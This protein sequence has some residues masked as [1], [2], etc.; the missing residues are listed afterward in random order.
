M[1][2]NHYE[3]NGVWWFK[4]QVAGVLYRRSLRTRSRTVAKKLAAQEAAKIREFAVSGTERHSYKEAVLKW[5]K[6]FLT[7]KEP[8]TARRYVSSAKQLHSH[9]SPLYV[10]QIKPATI[11]AYV[12]IRKKAGATDV[13]IRRDLTA[14][15]SILRMCVSWGWADTNVAKLWDRSVLSEDRDA[16]HRLH[17]PSFD[18]V[19]AE[20]PATLA[21]LMRFL[22]ATGM[23]LEEAASLRRDQIKGGDRLFITKTKTHAP[24]TII[25]SAE[26]KAIVAAQPIDIA[27]PYVFNHGANSRYSSASSLFGKVRQR[28]QKQAQKN[29]VEFVRFRLHDLRH[30]FAARWLE[31]GGNIYDLSRHLGHDS[32]STTERFYLRFVPAE[33]VDTARKSRAQK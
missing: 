19:A 18:A 8:A 9:F 5:T 7:S 20:A 21:A 31:S 25:L 26:A 23:R 6:E 30:E 14:L 27:S 1:S 16:I 10:D 4:V 3:R 29:E 2:D 32:V 22:L 17:Q 33:Q 28:A 13:T 24:R 15:S 12:S 11:A